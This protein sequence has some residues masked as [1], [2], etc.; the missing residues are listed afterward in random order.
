MGVK[1]LLVLAVLLIC[2]L[3]VRAG[4]IGFDESFSLADDREVPLK[5]L[6]PGTDEHF[7]YSCLHLQNRGEYQKVDELVA[8]W[9]KRSS[10]TSQVQEILN[11]QALLK[12]PTDPQGSLAYL[13]DK[14]NLRFQHQK[15]HLKKTTKHPSR[16][17]AALIARDAFQKRA[18][19][20]YE[21][22][23]GC[24]DAAL[25]ILRATELDPARRRHLL[26]RMTR[27]D[28]GTA[29]AR[30][31]VEDL[32]AENSGGFGSLAV[33]AKLTREQLAECARLAPELLTMTTFVNAML[34]KLQ[35]SADTD[36]RFDPKEKEAYLTRLWAFAEPLPPVHNSLKAC[37]LY[38]RL[39]HDQSLGIHDKDRFLAYLRLPRA[40]FYMNARWLGT[41]ENR[42]FP[43]DLSAD[44]S[45]YTQL[46]T[47]GDDEPL[48]R[49]YLREFLAGADDP[50]QFREYLESGWLNRLF[51]ETKLMNGAPNPERWYS[52]LQP[53]DLQGLRE[54]V[55]IEFLPTNR[56]VLGTA[57]PVAL[58]VAVK[59][60][61]TLIIKVFRI[62]AFTHYRESG[63]ELTTGIDLDGLV[64]N[65]EKLVTFH[66][67]E[68]RR[69]I[70][71]FTFPQITEPGVYVVELIG[72]GKSSRALI[73]KG[74]LALTQRIG[75]AGHVFSVYDET[76]T[77]VKDAV[78][79]LAGHEYTA[80]ER[81]EYTVP[82]STQPGS[83]KLIIRR[84]S[85]AS[86][87]EF[88][89]LSESYEL[90]GSFLVA[91]ESLLE[92]QIATAAV[93][94]DLTVNGFPA[95]ISLLKQPRLTVTT[96]D[97]EG[98]SAAREFPEPR[99][100]NAEE[101]LVSFRVPENLARITFSLTGKV[102]NL[103]QGKK[104]DL[105]ISRTIE[106]NGIQATDRIETLFVRHLPEGYTIELLGKT[107]EPL[108]DRPIQVQVKHRLFRE[109]FQGVLQTAADGRIDLG[110]L[111]EIEEVKL[112]SPSGSSL[113]VRPVIAWHTLPGTIH[114]LAGIPVLVPFS[115][116]DDV[117]LGELVSLFE[118]NG[119]VYV[120][121][122]LA[123]VKRQEGYLSIEGLEAGDY[124]LFVKP[125]ARPITIRVTRGKPEGTFLLSA[126]RYLQT[127][128][129]P[130]V[131]ITGVDHD[132]ASG[133]VR[134]QL[135]HATTSTRVHVLATRYQPDDDLYA[136]LANRGVPDPVQI[137]CPL[138]LS[139]YLSG[140]TIGDELRYVLERKYATI[141]PGNMLRRPGLLLNP[142]SLRKTD[143]S[144][145]EAAQ[146]DA[147]ASVPEAEPSVA[148]SGVG[149]AGKEI[150]QGGESAFACLNFLPRP[151]FTLFNLK[152]DQNGVVSLETA[153]LATRRQLHVIAIDLADVACRELS[154]P[155]E[156]CAP[157]DLRMARGLDPKSH[158]SEQKSVTIASAGRTFTIEEASSAKME[159]Y[160]TLGSVCNLF[161]ALNA[162]PTMAEFSFILG[163]PAKT[164]EE[165][166]ALYSKYACHELNFFLS[167][168]DPE[169][170]QAVIKP[171]LVSKKDKTFL[172]HWL[173]GNDLR[174][175]LEPWAYGRLNV[176]ERIL[177]ARRIEGEW[178]AT[179]R[180][181]GDLFDL[182]PPDAE[183]FNR[184]FAAAL[185]GSALETDTVGGIKA[186]RKKKAMAPPPPP[187]PSAAPGGRS[188]GLLS[189][190]SAST[191]PAKPM[192][193][194]SP[195]ASLAGKAQRRDAFAKDEEDRGA[196]MPMEA[197]ELDTSAEGFD[198][199][200]DISKRKQSR[201]SFRQ[202]DKTEEWVENNYWHLPIERH[203]AD[204][205]KVN[206]FWRDFAAC[207]ADRPFL[208]TRL[209]EA[210]N[211]FPEMMFALSLLDLPFTA[212][213]HELTQDDSRLHLKPGCDVVIFHQEI[214]PAAAP[215]KG[216][217]ILIGQNFFARD[218]RYRFENE[219]RFDKFVTE[220]FQT[221]RV[222]GCQIVLTNP[223]SARKKVDLLLQIP[224]G[225]IPVELGFFTRSRHQVL[226][227][228]STVTVEY[229][230]YFPKP[231]S[232]TQFPVHVAENGRY[233]GSADPFTFTVVDEPTRFDTTSWE[234]ISQNGTD[235]EVL[236]YL[237]NNNIGRLDLEQIAF[238]MADAG[239]FRKTL[240]LLQARHV[241]H[242]T[243][244]SYGLKHGDVPAI[245]EYLRHSA[246]P[247]NCGTTLASPLL[248]LDPVERFDYQHR[249][250]WPLVNARVY[251][252]GKK[253][254][255]LNAQFM[256]QYQALLA[257]LRYH[258]SLTDTDLMAVVYYLLLQDRVEEALRFFDRVKDP[259]VVD[260]IQY[261][262][263]KAYL[264]FSRRQ[265]E[266]AVEIAAPFETY[267][268]DR[269]R[270]LFRDVLAQAKEITGSASS[271]IDEEDR[272]QQQ[273]QLADTAPT[274]EMKVENREIT[275]RYK[276]L[277]TCQLN[278]YLMD[279]ELLFSRN[280]F[281]QDVTGQF[282]IIH[283]NA[284]LT[285]E[286]PA[287]R[288]VLTI[289]LP[290]ELKDR[291]V[292]IEA[293][294][295]GITRSQ[296]YYPNS[297]GI[298]MMETYGQVAV[299]AT[300]AGTPQPQVYVKVFARLK[301]GRTVFYKD[302]YTD[303]RG[304]FDYASLST[305]Q[306]EQVERFSI[307]I[308][309]D[310]L[311]SVVREA[312]PPSM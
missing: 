126:S 110:P 13:A 53:S 151:A 290:T 141:F 25:D 273:A 164:P 163:W 51:A 73:R 180:H 127:R 64:P 46:S 156:A 147:W 81:G 243:L 219:E 96:V 259:A 54:L 265:P 84:G 94:A 304:R 7:Y 285:I 20:Q 282:A 136:P 33:H 305:N 292:M 93:R 16:L 249:E 230:F 211:S 62:N 170:F 135:K 188:G 159:V 184:L 9:I 258:P 165:K 261:K 221:S 40:Q 232:F 97:H 154:L 269:W 162:D 65:E 177:L 256:Q 50:N 11:R 231:G 87:H 29:L 17:D 238:R 293:T 203:T 56:D 202:L 31:V 102:D 263:F 198:I 123:H 95:S 39:R 89:H 306:L 70:E 260:T 299:T 210:A 189:R 14:L 268:V 146:G 185:K 37:I 142:W 310:T 36:I 86:L 130:P 108:S 287:G 298:R 149:F 60:V 134:I 52:L 242:Q 44:F 229:F 74:R 124:E 111:P 178:E 57:D 69:H 114:A 129:M 1:L 109:P 115:C 223:T 75:A 302:G 59:N 218:D 248:T 179:K 275:L 205:I 171:Y 26:S 272:D 143:T 166:R 172:D 225:A 121:D 153:E 283:P 35:P 58:Q 182:I 6:I 206:G 169:F 173:L 99:L 295:S 224:N 216:S 250:Y 297:L 63:E 220:E 303:L 279:L 237:R 190:L 106:L 48:V 4:E 2:S 187:P 245:R 112:T 122:G 23:S 113:T 278:F 241:Y 251:Q 160:D 191:P 150:A 309:S 77:P 98:V 61:P 38:H 71:T 233:I 288:D 100:S 28:G 308:M 139:R 277:R 118:M 262:Y 240:D 10:Y 246:L 161:T 104:T 18:F 68:I 194:P 67:P 85:F 253:R 128:S 264:A 204:L 138:P 155:D 140:R 21:D 199:D 90:G 312:A 157:L 78:L 209:A 49:D 301:D 148:G 30:L 175:Y 27:P 19:A 215:E 41:E 144:T 8:Q 280:P 247:R 116:P 236:S 131:Q 32:K 212:P 91:R 83:R 300:D 133:I 101:T 152:P 42:R 192:A 227:P 186:D 286:L 307:L 226:D 3:G 291:N 158:Y 252:L 168:K 294:G 107:G 276:N 66:E 235:D 24:E 213:S 193:M 103:S 174:R 239:F 181:V 183:R 47:I 45:P 228:F 289:P 274:L 176:V 271:V 257:D 255:I 201:P 196:D 296:A 22:L 267:P 132:A 88:N 55:D 214:K 137:R 76:N 270:N 200:A 34:A 222:Y 12:Y 234:Y 15:K 125:F 217:A 195:Q 145:D 80:D 266:Q 167:R 117:P 284:T 105:S 79:W 207:P 120:T 43:V 311:G 254:K 5:Q 119:G 82:F 244:W 92:G 208:S 281:V 197:S 72:N